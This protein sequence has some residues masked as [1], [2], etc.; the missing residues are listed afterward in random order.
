MTAGPIALVT[1]VLDRWT[2]M[3]QWL[4]KLLPIQPLHI[5]HAGHHTR[6]RGGNPGQGNRTNLTLRSWGSLGYQTCYTRGFHSTEGDSGYALL[7]CTANIKP[8]C[9]YRKKQNKNKAP[10]KINPWKNRDCTTAWLCCIHQPSR[11]PI[12]AADT[13]AMHWTKLSSTIHKA[14]LGTRITQWKTSTK[15]TPT[16]V[17]EA[18]R[19]AQL[20]YSQSSTPVNL[21][22]L[23]QCCSVQGHHEKLCQ[24]YTASC[25]FLELRSA[26][27]WNCSANM[28]LVAAD[29][30]ILNLYKASYQLVGIDCQQSYFGK[31]RR[32][33]TTLSILSA[34][35]R[36]DIWPTLL[37]GNLF[38]IP[39]LLPW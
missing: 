2:R 25:P 21:Q 16:S 30:G 8:N 32:Y 9:H 24:H 31:C 5:N 28:K 4:L 36:F 20:T 29:M 18:K 37:P 15:P 38:G 23:G 22:R 1:L 7:V 33:V 13:L 34:G 14:A 10:T 17:R 27:L 3:G 19:Q 11:V 12:S 6:S 26:K 35:K 39:L